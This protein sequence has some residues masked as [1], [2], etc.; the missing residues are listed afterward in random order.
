MPEAIGLK[1][2]RELHWPS[3]TCG[4]VPQCNAARDLKVTTEARKPTSV[5]TEGICLGPEVKNH[6]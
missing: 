2:H 3:P 5:P 6:I 1:V 4:F